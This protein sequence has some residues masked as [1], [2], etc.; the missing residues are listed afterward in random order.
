MG[1]GVNLCI[2]HV[3]GPELSTLI[4]ARTP[5]FGVSWSGIW[6]G[7]WLNSFSIFL[8]VACTEPTVR[9]H[10]LMCIFVISRFQTAFSHEMTVVSEIYSQ[11]LK[12]KKKHFKS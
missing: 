10:R 9:M 2:L 8:L 6:P 7:I 12:D 1:K 4:F 3:K 11:Y 5:V